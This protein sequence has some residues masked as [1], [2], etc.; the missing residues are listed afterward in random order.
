MN[1]REDEIEALLKLDGMT[2]EVHIDLGK[3]GYTAI[4]W[5]IFPDIQD[6]RT[7]SVTAELRLDAVHRVW[8]R[9][10][11]F[12]NTPSASKSSPEWLLINALGRVDEFYFN[13]NRR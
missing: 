5:G 11:A 9:Y 10:L 3:R 8:E 6:R 1:L 13:P 7:V 4:V 12:R 2:L